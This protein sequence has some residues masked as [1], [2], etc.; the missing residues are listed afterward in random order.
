MWRNVYLVATQ[1]LLVT[2]SDVSKRLVLWRLLLEYINLIILR[3]F[4][5]QL[6]ACANSVYQVVFFGLGTRLVRIVRSVRRRKLRTKSKSTPRAVVVD[7]RVHC[8]QHIE[9]WWLM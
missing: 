9:Q 5:V 4:Y 8:A 3:R 6:C 1:E 2:A 7:V